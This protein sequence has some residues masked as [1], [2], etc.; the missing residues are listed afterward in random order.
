MNLA[1]LVTIKGEATMHWFVVG[2][3]EEA[4]IFVN[5]QKK[6]SLTLLKSL[7]NP[8]ATEKRRD[9]VRKQ[10][11]TGIKS[12]GKRG[13][14]H[15]GKPK[16]HDPREQ[17]DI[18]FAK[19]VAKYLDGEKVKNSFDSLTVVAEPRFL[20]KIR[21]EMS[22]SLKGSVDLWIKK[23]LQKI[24]KKDLFEFLSCQVTTTL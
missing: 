16:R 12:I 24:P 1:H 23:D 11:G 6:K 4:R 21:K 3:Q 17:A 2:S 14:I 19:I 22:A 9:L 5:S 18:Q 8:L 20:G 7:V 13:S 15:Y 10:A